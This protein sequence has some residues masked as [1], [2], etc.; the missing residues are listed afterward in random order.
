MSETRRLVLGVVAA[1]VVIGYGVTKT[2]GLA[3]GVAVALC[4]VMT[5]GAFAVLGDQ[6]GR[7]RARRAS[8]N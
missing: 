4:A 5:V 6:L 7:R 2:D 8:G 3:W 1:A